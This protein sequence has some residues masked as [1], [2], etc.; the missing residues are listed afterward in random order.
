MELVPS[1][2]GKMLTGRS[3]RRRRSLWRL[4]YFTCINFSP[5]SFARFLSRPQRDSVA[6]SHPFPK[7]RQTGNEKKTRSRENWTRCW[8]AGR[9]IPF[10]YRVKVSSIY[11][12]LFSSARNGRFR[13]STLVSRNHRDDDPNFPLEA[14]PSL[15]IS[16]S[17]FS[18]ARPFVYYRLR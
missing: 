9:V 10:L 7:R 8:P 15:L 11:F 4:P 3:A 12:F 6:S 13:P 18:A 14:D 5:F 17:P 2:V 16:L 1:F